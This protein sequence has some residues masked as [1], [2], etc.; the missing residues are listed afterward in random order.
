MRDSPVDLVELIYRIGWFVSLWDRKPGFPG[1]AFDP[2]DLI[3]CLQVNRTW[4]RTLTPLLWTVYHSSVRILQHVPANLIQTYSPHFR[5][6]ILSQAQDSSILAHVQSTRLR[7]LTLFSVRQQES[8]DLIK[9]NPSITNLTIG[10]TNHTAK[11]LG[12]ALES[13]PK[14]RVLS[15]SGGEDLRNSWITELLGN[16]SGLEELELKDFEELRPCRNPHQQPFLSITKLLFSS[17]WPMNPGFAQLFRF[18]PQLESLVFES[19]RNVFSNFPAEEVSRN[20]RECCSKFK[21]LQCLVKGELVYSLLDEDDICFMLQSTQRLVNFDMPIRDLTPKFCQTLVDAHAA[22]LETVRIHLRRQSSDR[23]LMANKILASCPQLTV[24]ELVAGSQ[25]YY[26]EDILGLFEQP[27]QCPNLRELKLTG[28]QT[29]GLVLERRAAF[30]LETNVLKEKV[31][32][33]LWSSLKVGD[34]WLEVQEEDL[35]LFFDD[36]GTTTPWTRVYAKHPDPDPTFYENLASRGWT[37][38]MDYTPAEMDQGTSRLNKIVHQ[39][40]FEQLSDSQRIQKVTLEHATFSR[41]HLHL[42]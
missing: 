11:L 7:E 15:L 24:F 38:S 40:V 22:H 28:F 2:K 18:C 3:A 12:E 1:Y 9:R 34:D 25:I 30:L 26:P 13:L 37:N 21:S 19:S 36:T 39:L 4:R 33:D 31:Q 20:L 29:H 16:V 10:I 41:T 23:F 27:W 14:L 5:Y 8:V 6:L 17:P 32:K 42:V 35:D